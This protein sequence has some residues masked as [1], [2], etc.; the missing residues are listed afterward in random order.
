MPWTLPRLVVYLAL[1]S[2]GTSC[3]ER[4]I[5]I[6]SDPSGADVYLNG[7]EVGKTPLDHPFSFYGTVEVALRADGH[8]YHR[9]LKTLS[10]PWYEV[11]PLD[12]FAELFLPWKV[13]DV[14]SVEVA[15]EPAPRDLSEPQRQDMRARSAELREHLPSSTGPV[16]APDPATRPAKA[17]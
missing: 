10:P 2:G 16:A 12:L 6:R 8:L 7:D 17:P 4:I 11:M 13:R 3:V 1:L 14:H 5:Q 9:E 15:L